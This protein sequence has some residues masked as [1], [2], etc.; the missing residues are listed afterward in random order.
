MCSVRHFT[1][2]TTENHCDLLQFV[3]NDFT[4]TKSNA[5][6]IVWGKSKCTLSTLTVSFSYKDRL[7]SIWFT[8]ALIVTKPF[9]MILL[10]IY[11]IIIEIICSSFHISL[12]KL[13]LMHFWCTSVWC[14]KWPRQNEELTPFHCWKPNM[15][16]IR[17]YDFIKD[18][19]DR[20]KQF[21]HGYS[22]KKKTFYL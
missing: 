7:F 21:V 4:Q 10:S 3:I 14:M 15:N 22:K 13:G 12:L 17:A 5:K 16:E 19:A 20:S 8:A 11:L 6:C 1:R 18:A 9:S 2:S